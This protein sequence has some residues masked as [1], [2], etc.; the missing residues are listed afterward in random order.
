MSRV[1]P[2]VGPR[3]VDPSSVLGPEA[4]P[5]TARSTDV[6]VIEPLELAVAAQIES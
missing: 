6:D 1:D 2:V 5:D 4:V 3:C